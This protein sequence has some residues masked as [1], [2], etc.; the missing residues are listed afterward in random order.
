MNHCDQPMVP[1]PACDIYVCLRCQ[2]VVS[3]EDVAQQRKAR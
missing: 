3:G 1:H 2:H